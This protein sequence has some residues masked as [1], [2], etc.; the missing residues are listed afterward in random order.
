MRAGD[1]QSLATTV[2]VNAWGALGL[3]EF[4]SIRPQISWGRCLE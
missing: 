2:I 4:E 3:A 1:L